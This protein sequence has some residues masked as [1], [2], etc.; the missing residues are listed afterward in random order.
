MELQIQ[1][2]EEQFQD[3]LVKA[4]KKKVKSI[5]L[6]GFRKGKAPKA[7]IEKM[8]GKEFFYDDAINMV[9]PAAY[10]AAVEEAKIEPV[11]RANVSDLQVEDGK[12]FSFKATVTVKPE[13]TVKNY[14]GI[15]AEKTVETIM[16]ADVN[17][18]LDRMRERNSRLTNV[19]RAA[20]NGDT[21]LIDFEGFI[22]GEAFEGGRE[23]MQTNILDILPLYVKAGSILPLAEVKQYAMEYPDRELELRIYGGADAAFLWYE[24]E[25]DSYRY[26]EGVCSKVPMQWKDSER[27]LTIGLREGTYPGMPEQIK[28]HVKLYLPEGAALDSK[29]CVY[30]GREV[31]IKF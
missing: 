21:A 8:Y 15:K 27:T 12:G 29:E 9:Y 17:A 16:A 13:V 28:M 1:V 19:E 10:E 2:S 6:P 18:E 3:A 4:Y 30:T 14:K 24:D 26:E 22:D 5:A 7:M 31:K 23:Q 25:G 20:K 11:D